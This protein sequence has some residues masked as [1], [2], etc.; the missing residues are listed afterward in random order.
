M[1]V[2]IHNNYGGFNIPERLSKIIKEKYSDLKDERAFR[3]NPYIINYI[4]SHENSSDLIAVEVPDDAT[5][6][7]IS[8]YDGR[9]EI[10]AVVDGKI[11]HIK[12]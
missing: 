8:D 7:E 3:S 11:I 12:E 10:I 9:E 6:W 2:A 1:L 4:I 5:D